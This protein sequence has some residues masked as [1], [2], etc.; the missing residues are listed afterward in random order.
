[1]R[2]AAERNAPGASVGAG[3]DPSADRARLG[4]ACYGAAAMTVPL[5][6]Q[7]IAL[8]AVALLATFATGAP[9]AESLRLNAPVSGLVPGIH[10][11]RVADPP[12]DGARADTT[13][14]TARWLSLLGDHDVEPA[15]LRALGRLRLAR[16]DTTGADS[17][18]AALAARRSVWQWEG[19]SRRVELL[20]ARES[21]VLADSLLF[22]ADR[23][24]WPEADRAAWLGS[25]IRTR[26]ALGDTTDAIR[27]ARQLMRLYPAL[28]PA[29][30]ALTRLEVLLRARGEKLAMDDEL[31]AADIERFRAARLSAAARYERASALAETPVERFHPLLRRAEVLR[32]GRRYTEAKLAARRAEAVAPE[33]ES[34]ARAVLEQARALRDGRAPDSAFA[35]FARATQL[36]ASG[37]LRTAA[38]WEWAREAED[39][40][41]WAD[42][43]GAFR[44]AAAFAG[45]RAEDACFRAGLMHFVL[46]APDSARWWWVRS[47]GEPARFWHA[48]SLRGTRR[49][50]ADSA[51]RA[52]AN[53]PGYTFYRAAARDTLGIRTWPGH[54]ASGRCDSL[55]PVS[56]CST[57]RA[58]ER[59]FDAGFVDDAL[60]LL[61]RWVAGDA[62][63]AS[64]PPNASHVIGAAALA[65]RANRPQVASTWVDRAIRQ[66]TGGP[67]SVIWALA[68]WTY[69][70]AYEHLFEKHSVDSLGLDPYTLMSVCRQESR[71]DARARSSGNAMGL[72]QLLRGT[73]RDVARWARDPRPTEETLYR[74]E[75]SVDYG[76]RYLVWL[77]RRF[78]RN[79]AVALAAYNAGPGSIPPH[80]RELLAI[81]GDALFCEFASND[82]S[83]DYARKILGYRQAYRELRP[84]L[85]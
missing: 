23:T 62:R 64:G 33:D 78:D 2:A 79:V 7:W 76:T 51:L 56:G 52:I 12:R 74:P 63:A 41:R 50:A 70:P 31:A 75:K 65:Y 4:G 59:L 68:P 44:E 18:F 82:D 40:G 32:E 71:F 69:P 81:G 14:L 43:L 34:R 1:M 60:L 84:T 48:V 73:A 25:R 37:Q 46:G 85:R 19:L 6:T 24:D 20:A 26:T 22:N 54:V 36:A 53:A 9:R 15:A 49:A 8:A 16:R 10:W 58:A 42:A 13:Q 30:R 55:P 66:A 39:Q 80:W 17:C 29:G 21:W 67:D 35:L 28:A 83:Q 57:L 72:M 45:T 11:E 38:A 3:R 77:V 47:G 27:L 5:R 61:S